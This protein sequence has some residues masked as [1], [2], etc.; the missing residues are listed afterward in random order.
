MYLIVLIKKQYFCAMK[1]M[2]KTHL[3]FHEDLLDFGGIA[4][5]KEGCGISTRCQMSWQLAHEE[6]DKAMPTN[7]II[8]FA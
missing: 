8:N 7:V 1:V 5:V 2:I 3:S 6:H 4:V